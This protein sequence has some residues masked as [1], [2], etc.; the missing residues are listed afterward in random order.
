VFD[1]IESLTGKERAIRGPPRIEPTH[2]SAIDE[3]L[4]KFFMI[5]SGMRSQAVNR[6]VR[7]N[8]RIV[9]CLRLP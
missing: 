8:S 9:S 2:T 5:T 3:N 1:W 4:N 7:T 6:P